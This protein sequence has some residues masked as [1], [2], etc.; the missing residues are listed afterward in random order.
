M[1]NE[2]T[3]EQRALQKSLFN[4]IYN[5]YTDLEV[6]ILSAFLLNN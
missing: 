1:N 3:T 2:R 4:K 6:K 5:D